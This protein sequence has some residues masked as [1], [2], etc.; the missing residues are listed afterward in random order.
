MNTEHTYLTIINNLESG[1][2]FVDLQRR[3][4]F[5]NPAAEAIS[6]YAAEEVMGT[7][8]NDNILC[9]IDE[10]GRPVCLVGCPLLSTMVDGAPRRA[11]VFL[12]HK[13]GHRIPVRV[14]V[15]PIYDEGKIVG[16]AE[17]FAP[18]SDDVYDDN[19]V[20]QL[21]NLAMQDALTG[22]PNR[23]YLRSFIE[24]KLLEYRRFGLGFALLFMD[25]DH[26][27]CF[28]NVHGH[29]AGD[30][31]LRAISDTV[32]K[33]TRHADIFGR[34]GGEE[35][36]GVY[37]IANE[38]DI[39]ALAEKTRVLIEGTQ[40]Q[41][42]QPLSVTASIGITCALPNDTS[43]TLVDRADKLMYQSKQGGRNRVTC[44]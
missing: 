1:V 37:T 36:V 11:E 15:M 10:Q 19:L 22:L 13:M 28:N 24:C 23:R 30:A 41:P 5:W 9:H 8:C 31:V 7:A 42:K 25:I 44:G 39:R 16:A 26:F 3:I 33:N 29:E 2:Y 17:I 21:S 43:D 14:H 20:T 32:R 27:G 40:I 12:R 4:T 38:A 34:W 35:F 18:N 6:G